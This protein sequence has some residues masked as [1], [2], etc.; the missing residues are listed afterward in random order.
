MVI[1]NGLLLAKNGRRKGSLLLMKELWDK[2][3]YEHLDL[4]SHNLRDQAARLKKSLGN[5]A[6]NIV[7]RVGVQRQETMESIETGQVEI[8]DDF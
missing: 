1:S 8:G 3:S 5:A 6:S 2:M 7:S 4:S